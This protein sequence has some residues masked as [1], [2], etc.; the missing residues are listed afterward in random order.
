[1][2]Q[3]A[4]FDVSPQ[5]QNPVLMLLQCRGTLL[6]M[7]SGRIARPRAIEAPPGRR[8]RF[9]SRTRV[10]YYYCY[11]YCYYYYYYHYYYYYY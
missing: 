6:W 4:H 2:L 1:M 9:C 10:S 11:Y 8:D 3:V 7:M 5:T